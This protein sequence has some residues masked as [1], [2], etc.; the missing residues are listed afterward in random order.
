[1]DALRDQSSIEELFLL[2][3]MP[4]GD[5]QHL[6]SSRSLVRKSHPADHRREE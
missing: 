2:E 4:A 5:D 3:P 1:M 6:R